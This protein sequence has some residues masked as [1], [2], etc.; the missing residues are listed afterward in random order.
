MDKNDKKVKT[1][2]YF[3]HTWLL[4]D[5]LCNDKNDKNDKKIANKEV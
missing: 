1:I 5:M 4:L 2:G 3:C